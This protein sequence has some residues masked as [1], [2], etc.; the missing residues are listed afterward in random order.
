M[1]IE[2]E[3]R[4]FAKRHQ[5]EKQRTKCRKCGAKMIDKPG[6]GIICSECGWMQLPKLSEED[7][8]E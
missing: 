1:S 7:A 4:R 5:K 3:I 2:R 6:Y 8:Y